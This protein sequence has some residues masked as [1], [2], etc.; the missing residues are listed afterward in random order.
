VVLT[1]EFPRGIAVDAAGNVFVTVGQIEFHDY[2]QKLFKLTPSGALTRMT[3]LGPKGESEG[4]FFSLT[5]LAIDAQGTLYVTDN[6][7]NV[8][9]LNKIVPSGLRPAITTQPQSQTAAA[10]NSASFSVG[11]SGTPA[12][13]YQWFFNQAAIGGATGNSYSLSNVQAKDAG[14]YSVVVTNVWGEV[15]SAKATLT[16][17]TTA[18]TPPPASSGSSASG[19]G[20]T[21]AWL[22]VLLLSLG[23]ARLRSHR[24]FN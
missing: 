13:N 6:A 2:E 17:G 12:P 10:G 24:G 3:V 18:T 5:G 4:V 9:T 8:N 20:S 1:A 21:E 7:V 11:A 14:D 16:L 15:T 22:G 23:V 19:G